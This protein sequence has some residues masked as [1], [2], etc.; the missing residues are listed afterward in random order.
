MTERKTLKEWCAE[1]GVLYVTASIKRRAAGVGV[2]VRGSNG[3]SRGPGAGWKLSAREWKTLL[4]T[5]APTGKPR[6]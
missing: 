2:L 1:T 5:P 3:G 4:A 6:S